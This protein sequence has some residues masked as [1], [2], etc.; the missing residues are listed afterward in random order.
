[1][2]YREQDHLT[3]PYSTNLTN[4][5]GKIIFRVPGTDTI[6][7]FSNFGK[8]LYQTDVSLCLLEGMS[9]LFALAVRN[10]GDDGLVLDKFKKSYGQVQFEV[11]SYHPPDFKM[12]TSTTVNV[13]RG[14]GLFTSLYGYYQFGLDIYDGKTKHVGIGQ[15][16]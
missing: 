11:Q 5:L 15:V 6:I 12:N 3:S 4:G 2:T 8:L 13:L 16:I 1:M 10:K 7:H 14:I 9:D